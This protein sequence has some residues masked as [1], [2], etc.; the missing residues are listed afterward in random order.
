MNS[1][2]ATD[3][4]LITFAAWPAPQFL[5]MGI[6]RNIFGNNCYFG[7]NGAATNHAEVQIPA[8]IWR[9][10]V[11]SAFSLDTP[12]NTIKMQNSIIEIIFMI[13]QW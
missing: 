3:T 8:H 5:F 7:R 12:A 1:T 6:E 10:N 11:T 2:G 9:L 13:V 4:L